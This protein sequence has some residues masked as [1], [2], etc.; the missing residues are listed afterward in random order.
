MIVKEASISEV[1]PSLAK[2]A[3]SPNSTS[4]LSCP[5]TE[6]KVESAS[7]GHHDLEWHIRVSLLIDCSEAS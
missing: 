7:R 4:G 1:C 2:G 6:P 3:I 5:S